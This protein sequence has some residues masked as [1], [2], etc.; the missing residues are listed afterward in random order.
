MFENMRTLALFGLHLKVL[1]EAPQK[2]L[3]T[4][5]SPCNKTTLYD[6]HMMVDATVQPNLNGPNIVKE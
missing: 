1:K 4:S 5:M 6:N 2:L 3:C